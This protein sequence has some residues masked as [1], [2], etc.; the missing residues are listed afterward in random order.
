MVLFSKY[1]DEYDC[2]S[3]AGTRYYIS[4]LDGVSIS[5]YFLQRRTAAIRVIDIKKDEVVVS[6]INHHGILPFLY[7]SLDKF[8][9]PKCKDIGIYPVVGSYEDLIR[10]IGLGAKTVQI[11]V[12]N[13]D[14]RFEKIIE[15][16][17]FLSREHNVQLFI[18]DHWELALKYGA[19]GIHLGQE[20]LRTA[21]LKRIAD[22]NIRLGVSSHCYYEL[23][24]ANS[25][26]PSYIA[27]G[28]IFHTTTKDMKF[29]VQG[30]ESLR[31]WIQLSDYPIVAIGGIN[32][33]N[34][35]KVIDIHPNGIAMVSGILDDPDILTR[36]K[37]P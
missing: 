31:D 26:N 6:Y 20:D 28:P 13:P 14:L 18:N 15:K 23:A 4:S 35:E 22:S 37:I 5:S 9:F 10:V 33:S 1:N 25:I 32:S 17:V 27:L 19:Y 21:D 29:N 8:V 24:I 30:V 3:I 2:F 34:I 11:R 16:S 12:K 36:Y 7:Y